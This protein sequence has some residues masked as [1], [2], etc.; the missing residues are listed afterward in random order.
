MKHYTQQVLDR[1]NHLHQKHE[2]VLPGVFIALFSALALGN[3]TRWSI[4]FDEAFSAYLMR[5]DIVELTRF[6]ALDV[7]PPLYY[8]LLKGWTAIFGMSELAFRSMSTLFAVIALLG[9]YVL[10][11]SC[12]N[13]NAALVALG[14]ASIL[15][16]LLRFADETR[17]YTLVTAIVIWAS[18]LLL[19][20]QQNQ[21]NKKG[22]VYYGLLLAAGMYTH[23]FAAFAWLAHWA[24]RWSEVKTGRM[25]RF[26]TREWV[27]VHAGAIALYLP[28]VIPAIK[29]FTTVQS[30]FWIPAVSAYTP[31]DYISNSWLYLMYGA[32]SG[33]F[34]VL[35]WLA[36]VLVVI[37]IYF[38][39]RAIK[40][41][42][43]SGY[44]M[45][46]FLSS[47][48]PLLMVLLSL[49]P[50]KSAFLDRYVLYSVLAL[51]AL[52]AVSLYMI[53]NKHKTWATITAIV[54][55]VSLSVGIYHVY[56]YG[57]YN[58]NSNFSIR[59]REAVELANAHGT[60]GQPIITSTP[61]LYYE[62]SFY[63]TERHKIYY[64]NDST[65]YE[66]GSLAMLK[67]TSQGKIVNLNDFAKNNRYVWYLDTP[68]ESQIAPP[69]SSWKQLKSYSVYDS[70]NDNAAYHIALYDTAPSVE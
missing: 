55:T 17:M 19:R 34:A 10:V 20:L 16:L 48:P 53:W 12:F 70:I 29:Q 26:W 41:Q 9:V 58:K 44:M 2:Y 47:V 3:I 6:T 43:R 13:R 67:E 68:G 62:A 18:W 61:W 24:W 38:A 64:L 39:S 56:Y 52:V 46:V 30:G 33:Y 1:L 14:F 36:V 69:D 57:N 21:S 11:R 22:W 37:T 15:P 28:W 51:V 4:W 63:D 42:Q 54:L 35:F 65:S 60:V 49:P 5:F 50:L 7:H 25:K 45:L 66:F 8:W 27:L 59:V 32:V 40:K 23:Y 31:V